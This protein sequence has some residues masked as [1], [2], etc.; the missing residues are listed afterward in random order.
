[1]D[2]IR[3]V[4][5]DIHG[6]E[7]VNTFVGEVIKLTDKTCPWV[8]PNASPFFAEAALTTVYDERGA[9]MK[10]DRDY[11]MEEEFVPFCEITGRSIKCF[12]RLSQAVL[13]TNA[14]ITVDYQSIG[15]HFV[16]RNNLVDW[17]E[18]IK[19]GKIPIP[20]SK[21]FNVPPT[22]PSSLHSHSIKT[23]ISDWYELTWFMAYL[24]N[25]TLTRD[26]EANNKVTAAVRIAFD[27]LKAAKTTR[28]AQLVAHDADYN[29][30]HGTTKFDILMG[31][32]DNFDTASLAEE[33]Q[34]LRNDVLSTPMGVAEL[35][36]TYKPD[37]NAAMYRG[38]MPLSR[39]GGDSFIPPNISGS[40]EGMGQSTECSGICLEPSGL[41]MLLSNHNDGRTQ[42]LYFSTV[43]NYNKDN[44]RITYTNYKYRPPVLAA[45]GIDVNRIIAGSG[46]KVIMVGVNGTND[47][48]VALTNNT[49]DPGSHS[50]VR[51]DMSQITA[52]FGSPYGNAEVFGNHDQATIHH[53]GAYLVFIQAWVEGGVSKQR[54]Y[55]CLT[56]D[57]RAGRNI[58]WQ[59]MALTYVDWE[60]TQYNGVLDFV[61]QK[62]TTNAQG[63]ITRFGRFLAQQPFDGLSILR[64][65]LSLSWAQTGG[66][67]NHYLH[68][69][70]YY[71]MSYIAL[72]YTKVIAGICEMF[73]VINPSN[74]AMALQSKPA[75]ASINFLPDGDGLAGYYQYREW[76]NN[77]VAFQQP[78]SV[79]LATGEIASAHVIEAGG[80]FP[81]RLQVTKF[82]GL[83]SG[84]AV[85]A[86]ALGSD[87]VTTERRVMTTPSIIPAT[88]NGTFPAAMTYEAD[89]EIFEAID[90]QSPTLARQGYFRLV[91]GGYAVR[92]GVNNLFIGNLY[93]RPLTT[94]IYKSNLQ[95]TDGAISITGSAAE[96]AAG[97]VE[98]GSGSLSFCGWSSLDTIDNYLPA[99]P[100]LRAPASGNVLISF[101][102]TYGRTLD[103]VNKTA[104][105]QGTTFFGMR[106]AIVDLIRSWMP[107]ANSP[108]WSFTM[109]YLSGEP[110]G[111]FRNL[112][113]ALVT[114]NYYNP[115]D[116]IPRSRLVLVRPVVEAPNA[117]HPNVWLITDLTVLHAPAPVRSY[118]YILATYR[119][120]FYRHGTFVAK[121]IFTGYRDGNIIKVLHVGGFAMQTASNG[122]SPVNLIFD[123]NIATNQITNI[124]SG[125]VGSGYGDLAVMIPGQGMTDVTVIPNDPENTNIVPTPYSP[126]QYTGGGA[127]LHRKTG[128]GNFLYTSVYPETGWV[129]FCQPNIKMM[130]NGSLYE[131][132]GGNI[133]LRD[134][135]SAPQ[136]KTF[137]VYA[138]VEDD[139]P[140]YIISVTKMRKSG[141]MLKAATIVTNDK[142]I[143]TI[144]RHQPLMIGPYLLS[145]TREGGII[146]MSTGFPHDE[147]DFF[148]L[149]NAELLP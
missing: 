12:I 23:E 120:N 73:Y 129:L 142:Q 8:I 16:P 122:D 131:M 148:M 32:H 62:V 61:M 112:N 52:K 82:V 7:P 4:K 21:V 42:G 115:A 139:E 111:T 132:G 103:Q 135:D 81:V 99:N 38:I 145:Y 65:A 67:G 127:A 19:H 71:H 79:V 136:N 49:F 144:T 56:E 96:L 106:Q 93:S 50:Y 149:R 133:D 146:P 9:E 15:A 5:F 13:D 134:V 107:Q 27:R 141:N 2:P 118:P 113:L 66:G 108:S 102:R 36:K 63:K 41:M 33:L 85:M 14:Q 101:P 83:N 24:S 6:I 130:V 28:L 57:V 59:A 78:S 116:A 100:L 44:I 1:M 47:W 17:L 121:P 126:Y 55:R 84:E 88:R 11:F 53:M 90:Q 22:L 117:S 110:G 26:P 31:N 70:H 48:F 123:L 30:P 94:Q 69:M 87:N 80:E 18:K 45:M 39:F 92:D 77:L 89:G 51:C 95:H 20:W 125:G 124:A 43:E 97:G 147:G 60:G 86:R 37:T 46:N 58:V 10:L 72:P 104:T 140:K 138:T 3:L 98:C 91:S 74:G 35:A 76:T 54:F 128:V 105:Y 109:N 119:A 64:R 25:V 114:I 75:Q 137:Y 68:M 40:F 143:L 34:G 29:V